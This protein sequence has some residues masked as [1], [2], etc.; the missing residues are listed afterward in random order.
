M[1]IDIPNK[2]MGER[3][4]NKSTTSHKFTRKQR[5][6]NELFEID[7]LQ[8]GKIQETNFPGLPFPNP[9]ASSTVY[10]AAGRVSGRSIG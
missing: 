8:K 5:L 7:K 6:P 2:C 3:E 4:K 1:L 9:Q 10:L